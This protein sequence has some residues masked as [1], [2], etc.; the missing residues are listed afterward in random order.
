MRLLFIIVMTA[1]GIYLNNSRFV[2]YRIEQAVLAGY[3][4]RPKACIAE[5]MTS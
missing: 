1:G 5:V 3:L 2:V 4:A